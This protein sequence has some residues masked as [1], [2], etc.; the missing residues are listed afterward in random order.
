M[1]QVKQEVNNIFFYNNTIVKLV[2]NKTIYLC[3]NI[4]FEKVIFL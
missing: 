2:N 3:Y 1:L 4:S